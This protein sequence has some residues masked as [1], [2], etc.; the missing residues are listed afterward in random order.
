MGSSATSG[1]FVGNLAE[2]AVDEK[3]VPPNSPDG[4]GEW[5]V[6]T[7]WELDGTP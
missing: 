3:V 2:T 1:G 4:P 6:S 5:S 7:V